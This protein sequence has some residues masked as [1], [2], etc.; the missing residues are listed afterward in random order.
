LTQAQA[1]IDALSPQDDRERS[2]TALTLASIY[3]DA[4]NTDLAVEILLKAD[5]AIPDT[6]EI[7]YDLAML[8]ERQ[9]KMDLFEGLMRRVIELDP[10]TANAYNSLGYTYADQ[11]RN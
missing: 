9:G 4:G 10:D 8:C 7:K 3:R 6:P 2:V 5:K 1:T 11:N